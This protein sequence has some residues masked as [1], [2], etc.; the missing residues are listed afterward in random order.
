MTGHGAA[1]CSDAVR[2]V[3]WVRSV[4]SPWRV[5][6]AATWQLLTALEDR[7]SPSGVRQDKAPLLAPVEPL[8]CQ[9]LL[10]CCEPLD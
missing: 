4:V 9:G 6:G 8:K 3:S 7:F 10:G 1:G 5:W 2:V